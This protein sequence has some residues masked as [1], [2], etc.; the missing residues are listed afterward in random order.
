MA[1]E[2]HKPDCVC[3]RCEERRLI[4]AANLLGETVQKRLFVGWL[5][6]LEM[7][8]EESSLTLTDPDGNDVYFEDFGWNYSGISAAIDRSKFKPVTDSEETDN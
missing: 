7:C 2:P 3:E 8:S 1:R 4:D 5:I 6:S